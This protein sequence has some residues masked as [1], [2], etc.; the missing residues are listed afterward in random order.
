MV[1]EAVLSSVY[2]SAGQ[3]C[4]AGSVIVG[5]GEAYEPI[6]ERI[7][8]GAASLKMGRGVDEGVEMGPVISG[9]HR[10]RVLRFIDE[11]ERDGAT[12]LLDGRGKTVQ[13]YPDGHWIGPTVF[14]DVRPDTPLGSEEVFGPVAGLARA[15]SLDEALALVDANPY[16]KRDLHLHHVR[17][18]GP[19]N[20][21]TGP[22][23]P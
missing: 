10:D 19:V 12:I 6:K 21:G 7:V 18:G 2:G 3:R 5:V 20:S 11:G 16:W 8:D 23:S 14:E 1:S 17:Q 9:S 15:G 4:L 13:D 22:A